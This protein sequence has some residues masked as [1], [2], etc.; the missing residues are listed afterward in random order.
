[1]KNVNRIFCICI[2]FLVFLF[3]TIDPVLSSAQQNI[4][5]NMAAIDGLPI[6]PDNIFNYNV[7]SS[8]SC[9]VIVNGTIR[10]RNSN[11][12]ISYTFNCNLN[13]GVNNFTEGIVHP[14]WQ[15]SNSALKELFFTH[16]ILP[17]GTF[18]YCINII[19]TTRSPE[20]VAAG[21]E[22]CMFK[23]ASDIFLINLV[24]P[25]NKAKLKEFNPDLTWMANYLVS[26]ELTYR[27]RVAEIKKGQNP[28]NA[29]MRNQ[30]VYQESSLMQNAIVY[31]VFAKPLVVNQPYAWTV[32]AYYKGILLGGSE[33]WEFIIPDSIPPIVKVERS[34]IDI[35][36][37][38]GTSNIIALGSLKLK[39]LLDDA[40]KDDLELELLNS[41]NQKC[42]LTNNNFKAK[43]GDNRYKIDFA[44]AS[45]L[46]HKDN[47]VLNI[48]TK[49]GHQY[50]LA[51]QYFNPEF[52]R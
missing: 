10:Y 32:D 50:K 36:R 44:E 41:Q 43:Y 2:Q 14:Q 22:E 18:E 6:T 7:Q 34:Y 33:T 38:N 29:V 42:K 30:P 20:N 25:E 48:K 49:T 12:N 21:F 1:M 39:Y 52:L 15:F 17:E 27:I 13:S 23:R 45:N 9:A 31:P 28:V 11:L 47:Y 46:K 8:S 19:P 51:F 24:D 26:N 37:E 4:V 3:L 5:I 40:A 35:K 16:K